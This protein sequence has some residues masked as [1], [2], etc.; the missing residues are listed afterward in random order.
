MHAFCVLL[1][2]FCTVYPETVLVP[3]PLPTPFPGAQMSPISPFELSYQ[4]TL[5]M[6]TPTSVMASTIS[7][8]A[9]MP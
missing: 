8:D 2:S 4:A 3:A 6:P 1:H 7:C 5:L 9:L